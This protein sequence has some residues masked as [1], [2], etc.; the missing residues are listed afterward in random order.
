MLLMDIAYVN[1][2]RTETCCFTFRWVTIEQQGCEFKP[3]VCVLVWPCF[4]VWPV[5]YYVYIIIDFNS[6]HN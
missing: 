6:T 1:E 5:T 2:F 4:K 3:S